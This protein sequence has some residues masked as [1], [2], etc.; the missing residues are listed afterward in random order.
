MF[1]KEKSKLQMRD[2][3]AFRDDGEGNLFCHRNGWLGRAALRRHMKRSNQS[4]KRATEKTF[5]YTRELDRQYP[6]LNN[7]LKFQ[8]LKSYFGVRYDQNGETIRLKNILLPCLKSIYTKSYLKYDSSYDRQYHSNTSL[9]IVFSRHPQAGRPTFQTEGKPLIAAEVMVRHPDGKL[10]LTKDKVK[11]INI[12][13]DIFEP[14][15]IGQDGITHCRQTFILSEAAYIAEK[16]D[17]ECHN[18]C[19][20]SVDKMIRVYTDYDSRIGELMTDI[21]DAPFVDLPVKDKTAA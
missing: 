13:K 16:K 3:A 11:E 19:E 17:Q 7:R 4:P 5:E 8:E 10:R 9:Y 2:L 18:I 6:Q 15:V 1:A 14:L 21:I 20:L 12:A